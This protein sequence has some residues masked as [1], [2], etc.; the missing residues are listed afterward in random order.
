QC[1]PYMRSVE[2]LDGRD[3]VTELLRDRKSVLLISQL[4]MYGRVY[5]HHHGV[6]LVI[7]LKQ[8]RVR[9]GIEMPGEADQ[10][11]FPR[12]LRRLQRLHRSVWSQ[13]SFDILAGLDGVDLPKIDIVGLQ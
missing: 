6:P 11:A 12:L 4:R 9:T 8:R 5:R 3:A 2:D 1:S 13:N 7:S 10:P